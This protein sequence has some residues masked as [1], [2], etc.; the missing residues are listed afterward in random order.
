MLR[1]GFFGHARN[2]GRDPLSRTSAQSRCR[3]TSTRCS[4]ATSRCHVSRAHRAVYRDA[5]RCG[6][7]SQ[8]YT[9][10]SEGHLQ[11]SGELGNRVGR[12][13][14][15]ENRAVFL[16]RPQGRLAD[17]SPRPGSRL[18]GRRTTRFV[19]RSRNKAAPSRRSPWTWP[20]YPHRSHRPSPTRASVVRCSAAGRLVAGRTGVACGWLPLSAARAFAADAEGLAA[21][22]P[23]GVPPTAQG[24]RELGTGQARTGIVDLGRLGGCPATTSRRAA[25]SGAGQ[26]DHRAVSVPTAPRGGIGFFHGRAG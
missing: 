5:P 21:A 3:P 26:A 11:Q 15:L 25:E 19:P 6:Q 23:T 9:G 8:Q 12:G 17:R 18:Q 24:R 2:H 4:K 10:H 16:E 1:A 20:S 22:F 7:V 13:T 14:E